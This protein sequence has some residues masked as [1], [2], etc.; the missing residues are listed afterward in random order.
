[1]RETIVPEEI[2]VVFGYLVFGLLRK[3]VLCPLFGPHLTSRLKIQTLLHIALWLLHA[4]LS[5]S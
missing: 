3:T 5:Y 1:M 2:V 4:L